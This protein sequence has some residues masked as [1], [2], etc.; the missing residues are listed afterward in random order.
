MSA[1]VTNLVSEGVAAV[2]GK[3]S[4]IN[5]SWFWGFVGAIGVFIFQEMVRSYFA[6]L[7]IIKSLKYELDTN[8]RLLD[9]FEGAVKEPLN[10]ENA[11]GSR[12]AYGMLET[13]FATEFYRSGL[14]FLY[15]SVEDVVEWKAT[16]IMQENGMD[17]DTANAIN[18]ILPEEQHPDA[19]KE[20]GPSKTGELTIISETRKS[21]KNVRRALNQRLLW[22]LFLR[23]LTLLKEVFCKS[24]KSPSWRARMS[25]HEENLDLEEFRAVLST[26][27]FIIRWIIIVS[28]SACVALLAL[29][30][31]I[32]GDPDSIAYICILLG[33]LKWFGGA[34]VFGLLAGGAFYFTQYSARYY[35]REKVWQG[36]RAVTIGLVSLAIIL[37]GIGS[38]SLSLKLGEQLKERSSGKNVS[39]LEAENDPFARKLYDLTDEEIAIVEGKA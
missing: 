28:G 35:K 8:L 26:S 16:L 29:I 25:N 34:T 3:L 13:H 19:A 9:E 32:W 17:T 7:E 11:V 21:L 30:G 33:T 5:W 20:I 4:G 36:W 27:K 38:V 24:G 22:K 39:A 18:G 6:K 10:E 15:L 12:P 14:C 2:S 1:G 23:K 31:N 37:L